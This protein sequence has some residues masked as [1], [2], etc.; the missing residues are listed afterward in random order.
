MVDGY[1]SKSRSGV[2]AVGG[3]KDGIEEA[4]QLGV[5]GL[6]PMRFLESRDSFERQVMV[7]L[8]QRIFH[9]KQQMQ[10]SLAIEIANAVGKMLSG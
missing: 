9:Y 4:A 2:L 7:E 8:G 5:L 10:K 1:V 6:D 3:I